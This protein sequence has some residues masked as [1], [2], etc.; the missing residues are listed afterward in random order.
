MSER[1][2]KQVVCLGVAHISAAVLAVGAH[3]FL[4]NVVAFRQGH[5]LT[6]LEFVVGYLL[7]MT[8]FFV[9]SKTKDIRRLPIS[10]VL[11]TAVAFGA[12]F[13]AAN[14]GVRSSSRTAYQGA[15][16]LTGPLVVV[17]RDHVCCGAF[18]FRWTLVAMLLVFCG[19]W[20]LEVGLSGVY[21]VCVG[22]F[23]TFFGLS[24]S[25]AAAVFYSMVERLYQV[26]RVNVLSLYYSLAP[27]IVAVLVFSLPVLSNVETVYNYKMTI[28]TVLVMV[29]SCTLAVVVHLTMFA[30]IR[31]TSANTLVF[32]QYVK[33]SLGVLISTL[34]FGN[35]L[36]WQRGI[37]C[38][39]FVLGSIWYCV[40]TFTL[41]EVSPDA[42]YTHVTPAAESFSPLLGMSAP[43]PGFLS[44]PGLPLRV[45]A[46]R[47][48]SPKRLGSWAV[49][50]E[51]KHE[52]DEDERRDSGAADSDSDNENT[53]FWK[54]NTAATT[55]VQVGEGVLLKRTESYRDGFL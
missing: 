50:F 25:V 39:M 43:K 3:R 9:T 37:G 31:G 13:L 22:G 49:G 2:T 30:L 6:I 55:E 5:L 41:S 24:A 10:E 1:C 21:E 11:P 18:L 32:T 53:P 48:F 16:L 47:L 34:S 52:D 27:V 44:S 35:P 36:S 12:F 33:I 20:L 28:D 29:L 7:V 46:A 45:H 54:E 40:D 51:H 8:Y 26:H 38:L 19:V 17:I 4:A 23:T 42:K 14:L 15:H